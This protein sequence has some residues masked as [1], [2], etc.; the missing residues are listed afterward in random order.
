MNLNCA[1]NPS[2][3]CQGVDLFVAGGA[4]IGTFVSLSLVFYV[5]LVVAGWQI[6]KKAG[7]PGWKILI[8]IYNMYML[9]KIVGMKN[10]FWAIVVTSVV[11]GILQAVAF[12]SSWAVVPSVLVTAFLGIYVFIAQIMYAYRTSKVFGHGLGF[13]LGLLF[14]PNLFWLIIAFGSSKYDKKMFKA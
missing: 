13:T 9:Y 1:G 3:N 6:L 14:L 2:L 4:I 12:N 7:Q 10:W 11:S 5:L 8:P